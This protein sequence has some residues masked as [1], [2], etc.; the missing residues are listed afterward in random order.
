MSNDQ[1]MEGAGTRAEASG[2]HVIDDVSDANGVAVP[3]AVH[4]LLHEGEAKG[5]LGG[6]GG[7]VIVLGLLLLPSGSLLRG[8]GRCG[9][10]D[11]NG[12]VSGL[13]GEKGKRVEASG[14]GE[15]V[16][17]Q[18]ETR[19]WRD[20]IR[21]LAFDSGNRGFSRFHF[22]EVLGFFVFF[23]CSCFIFKY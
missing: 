1:A 7:G 14:E 19:H 8:R 18:E 3:G 23:F 21:L 6:G 2:D 15:G 17:A 10:D 11:Q 13:G 5:L 4:K 16:D 20:W 22:Q 12:V 9:P